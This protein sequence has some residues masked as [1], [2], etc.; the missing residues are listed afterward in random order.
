MK[1]HEIQWNPMKSYEILWNPMKSTVTFPP[2]ISVISYT[3]QKSGSPWRSRRRRPRL[4]RRRWWRDQLH[5][6]ASFWGW[7]DMIWYDIICVYITYMSVYWY[8]YICMYSSIVKVI[9]IY[10]YI[11]YILYT[12]VGMKIKICQLFQE[13]I[14]WLDFFNNSMNSRDPCNMVLVSRHFVA[15]W[16]DLNVMF[17]LKSLDCLFQ[18]PGHYPLVMSK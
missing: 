14:A 12:H 15:R 13:I 10:I 8:K 11:I 6:L 1:S 3:T 17:A 16:A 5:F 18:S 7:Y 2:S 9:C 4:P